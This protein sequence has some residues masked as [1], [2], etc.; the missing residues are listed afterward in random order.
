MKP[1]YVNGFREYYKANST[2][3]KLKETKF[4][5]KLS[6]SQIKQETQKYFKKYNRRIKYFGEILYYEF[7]NET[8]S[9]YF[10]TKDNPL[11]MPEFINE[12]YKKKYFEMLEIVKDAINEVDP[13]DII[14][15]VV[16]ENEYMPE[17]KDLTKRLANK[18]LNKKKIFKKTKNVFDDWFYKEE[19]NTPK[20]WEIAQ[21]IYEFYIKNKKVNNV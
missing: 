5:Q 17:S 13:F 7:Y 2:Y 21:K 10:D 9:F 18:N 8:E 6:N 1:M 12:E 19:A 14:W 20:Y 4:D 3:L 15:D 16:D 11:K